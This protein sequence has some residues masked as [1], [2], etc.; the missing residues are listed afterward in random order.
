MLC[1]PLNTGEVTAVDLITHDDAVTASPPELVEWAYHLGLRLDQIDGDS[2]LTHVAFVD[3]PV[4]V[5]DGWA[6]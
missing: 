3:E 1:S 6:A 5:P 4:Y 2:T